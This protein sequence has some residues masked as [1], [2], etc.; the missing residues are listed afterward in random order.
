MALR[1]VP[2]Q[3]GVRER[4]QVALQSEPHQEARVRVLPR[5][6]SI[7]HDPVPAELAAVGLARVGIGDWGGAG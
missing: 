7:V 4:E 5:P 3:V 2:V 1:H 6:R